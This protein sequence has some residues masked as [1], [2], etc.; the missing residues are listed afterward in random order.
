MTGRYIAWHGVGT[1]LPVGGQVHCAV[2]FYHQ[3][4]A[5]RNLAHPSDERMRGRHRSV[6]KIVVQ[7]VLINARRT[8]DRKECLDLRRECEETLAHVV[9]QRQNAKAIAEQMGIASNQIMYGVGELAFQ[10]L[11]PGW[12]ILLIKSQKNFGVA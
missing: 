11:D 2:G 9:V 7:A 5:L 8:D 6:R 4:V 12:S 10:S 3:V 1:H